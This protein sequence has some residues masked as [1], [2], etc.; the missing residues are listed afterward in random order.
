MCIDGVT[1]ND[2]RRFREQPSM[3]LREKSSHIL[4]GYSQVGPSS[5]A[6]QGREE[7]RLSHVQAF[8]HAL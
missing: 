1:Q 4:L 2:L 8:F 5:K 3:A 7:M 6:K